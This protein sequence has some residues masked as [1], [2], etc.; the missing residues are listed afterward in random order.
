MLSTA[1]AMSGKKL[2]LYLC[3]LSKLS[4][5]FTKGFIPDLKFRSFILRMSLCYGYCLSYCLILMENGD[6]DYGSKEI[7]IAEPAQDRFCF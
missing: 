6:K 7:D 5:F 4:T 1:E 3:C 2:P